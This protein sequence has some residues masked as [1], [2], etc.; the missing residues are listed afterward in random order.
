MEQV[1]C[2]TPSIIGFV[3]TNTQTINMPMVRNDWG[4]FAYEEG[5][6]ISDGT[7]VGN[8]S[9]TVV[10]SGGVLNSSN[11]ATDPIKINREYSVSVKLN[12]G[13]NV[14]I[15]RGVNAGGPNVKSIASVIVKINDK[16]ITLSATEELNGNLTLTQ[17][18]TFPTEIESVSQGT[19][20]SFTVRRGVIAIGVLAY[21][22]TPALAPLLPALA[23]QVVQF[24][25]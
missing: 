24:F 22:F 7:S 13:E 12:I 10:I 25:S 14:A 19:Y 11:F 9:A 4:F 1:K 18:N 6:R 17:L 21:Y 20:H 5:T 8:P 16:T 2:E 3:G 15:Q 23:D